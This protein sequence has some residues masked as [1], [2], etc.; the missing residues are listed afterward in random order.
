M[1]HIFNIYIYLNSNN[2]QLNTRN[3]LFPASG[4]LAVIGD[5]KFRDDYKNDWFVEDSKTTFSC[6]RDTT[7]LYGTLTFFQKRDKFKLL[8][9]VI[10]GYG[11]IVVKI[12]ISR[13]LL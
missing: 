6:Y 7:C 3:K 12:K 5:E 4:E 11:K 1:I 9:M 13:I 8:D 10:D 2:L